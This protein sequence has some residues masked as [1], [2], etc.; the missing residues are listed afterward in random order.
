MCVSDVNIWTIIPTGIPVFSQ[1]NN[2][3]VDIFSSSV[4][5]IMSQVAAATTTQSVMVVCSRAKTMVFTLVSTA[6]N[7]PKLDQE[8]VHT[9]V[10]L[11]TSG[12]HDVVLPIL[13]II[14]DI[15]GVFYCSCLCNIAAATSVPHTVS[16]LCQLFIGSSEFSLS[17]FEPQTNLYA[18]FCCGV[19]F[20]LSGSHV[21]AML[22]TGAQPLG[23]ALPQPYGVYH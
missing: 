16:G 11:E 8:D 19:C 6:V 1:G 10:D 3:I 20:L 4:F 21:A 23:F 13:V 15:M 7:L 5:L 9:A 17:E 2:I 12:Q 18:C 22:T 14:R